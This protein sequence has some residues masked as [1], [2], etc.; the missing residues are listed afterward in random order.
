MALE[1]VLESWITVNCCSLIGTCGGKDSVCCKM[2]LQPCAC[3]AD[4]S[5]VGF[6]CVWC[7][8]VGFFACFF[9]L[10]QVHCSWQVLCSRRFLLLS[11][12]VRGPRG[13]VPLYGRRLLSDHCTRICPSAGCRRL[14][15]SGLGGGSCEG[16]GTVN[17][18]IFFSFSCDTR[19]RWPHPSPHR[20]RCIQHKG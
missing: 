2:A 11:G 10:M 1:G 18:V 7:S 17:R 12:L 19:G 3:L 16:R 14:R 13:G 6:P 4:M 9:D 15:R 5:V 8:K 20:I